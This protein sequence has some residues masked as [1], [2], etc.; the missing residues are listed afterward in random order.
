MCEPCSLPFTDQLFMQSCVWYCVAGALQVP[1]TEDMDALLKVADS[2][3][4]VERYVS[5]DELARQAA[6]KAA[7]EAAMAKM[8][9]GDNATDR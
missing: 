7:E 3:V 1:F 9:G 5:E 2:E 8:G 4:K 6:A